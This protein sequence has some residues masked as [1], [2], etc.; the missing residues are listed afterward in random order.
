L[1]DNVLDKNSLL[2]LG[3]KVYLPVHK[4][5][6]SS[7]VFVLAK[8][9]VYLHNIR[10]H[11]FLEIICACVWSWVVLSYHHKENTD[12]KFF[13]DVTSCKLVNSYRHFETAICLHLH[14]NIPDVWRLLESSS[15]TLWDPPLSHVLKCFSWF[16][17]TVGLTFGTV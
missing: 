13:W 10:V 12:L 5:P 16:Q 6:P 9:S 1:I 17:A 4:N 8:F 3:Q 15:R 7:A 11:N 2:L 14:I